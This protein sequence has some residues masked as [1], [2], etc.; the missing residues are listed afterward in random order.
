MA[1]VLCKKCGKMVDQEPMEESSGG[2]EVSDHD[3][4][5]STDESW[6]SSEDSQADI[7]GDSQDTRSDGPDAVFVSS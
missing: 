2:S 3:D 4:S 7:H 1:P 6:S 5:E